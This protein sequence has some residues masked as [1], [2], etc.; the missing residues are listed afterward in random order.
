MVLDNCEEAKLKEFF[1]NTLGTLK[2]VLRLSLLT[3][4]FFFDGLNKVVF[5]GTEIAGYTFIFDFLSQDIDKL[6][7]IDKLN[8]QI[9]LNIDDPEGELYFIEGDEEEEE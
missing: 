2:A 7:Y 5:G 1:K 6:C 8:S 9:E 3:F 4:T